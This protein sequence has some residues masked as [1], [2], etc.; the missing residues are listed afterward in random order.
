MVTPGACRPEPWCAGRSGSLQNLIFE[1]H[2]FGIVSLKPFFRGVSGGEDLDVLRIANLLAGV[3][4]DKDGY[5]TIL[6]ALA[7]F[8]LGVTSGFGLLAFDARSIPIR[9]CIRK[10]RPSAAP[11]R[12]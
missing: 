11:I 12:Q 8:A 4:V 6:Y 9:A 3:D 2:A 1:C 5:H 10:S 7:L